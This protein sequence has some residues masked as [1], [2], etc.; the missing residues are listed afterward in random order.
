[1]KLIKILSFIYKAKH[2]HFLSV[3]KS[4]YFRWKWLIILAV[5]MNKNYKSCQILRKKYKFLEDFVV[6]GLKY[7][8]KNVKRRT[9]GFAK[10]F[11][12]K[13]KETYC[14]YCDNILTDENAT[15]DHIIPISKGGNNTQV[16]LIVCCKDC[17]NERGNL[18][19]DRY[20]TLK[21]KKY[22]KLKNKFFY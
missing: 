3:D 7:N 17:N 19:F 11:L 6:I 8:G 4:T 22:R 1:M 9:S 16:N 12:V 5:S 21:N 18:E 13:N 10:E 15:A 20:L 14:I 2:P